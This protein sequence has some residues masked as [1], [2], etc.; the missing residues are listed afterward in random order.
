MP[1]KTLTRR[2][3][4]LGIITQAHKNS[5]SFHF[6]S[7]WCL[8]NEAIFLFLSL[9]ALAT[10]TQLSYQ[11]IP[12]SQILPGTSFFFILFILQSLFFLRQKNC[13]NKNKN[14]TKTQQ[15]RVLT[16]H[17][18]KTFVVLFRTT[19]FYKGRGNGEKI[20]N[21]WIEWTTRVRST[22]ALFI[23]ARH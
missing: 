11:L 18:V 21:V 13:K 15:F 7:L 10:H 5:F 20:L 9:I 22:S 8:P 12:H 4:N 1:L 19:Y 14:T 16:G 3:K 6:T 23:W 2:V 17:G